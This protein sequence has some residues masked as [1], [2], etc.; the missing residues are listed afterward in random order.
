MQWLDTT[1][2]NTL[3][4]KQICLV[5]FHCH[6]CTNCLSVNMLAVACNFFLLSFT[7]VPVH[8]PMK[9]CSASE[10]EKELGAKFVH[11]LYY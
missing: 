5:S 3:V 1:V 6:K 9:K 11:P 2:S 7:G 8:T 10:K 4:K